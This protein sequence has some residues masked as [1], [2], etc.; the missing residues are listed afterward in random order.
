[1]ENFIKK[2]IQTK[3]GNDTISLSVGGVRAYNLE[4][5]YNKKSPERFKLFIGFKNWVCTNL[6]VSTDGF[7]G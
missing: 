3:I 5:L 2:S 7:Q 6:C 1:M 4:N